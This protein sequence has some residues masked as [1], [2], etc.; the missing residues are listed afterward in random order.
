MGNPIYKNQDEPIESRIKD[1]LSRMTV[2]EKVGQMTQIERS[3]ATPSVIK[4]LCIGSILSCGGSGPFEKATSSDWAEMVDS[5]QKS[6]LDSRLGIPILYG[7]D[8]VHGN[9]NVYGA[10]VFPHNI[11]LGA[12]RKQATAADMGQLNSVLGLKLDPL[13]LEVSGLQG[14]PPEGYPKNYPF[15]AGRTNVV[16]CA[17]HFVGD[18]GTEQGV[19]EGN[20]KVSYEDLE[21]IHMA[22]YLDCLSQ[23]VCTVMAS[24]SSWNGTNLH[25][26]HFLLTEILK[27]KLGFKVMVPFRYK[28]YLEDLTHLVESGEIP[29]SRIDDA[30]ERI[31]RVKFVV[32]LFEYP[33]SDKS[34]L[35]SVGS[36]PRKESGNCFKGTVHSFLGRLFRRLKLHGK[37]PEFP[38]SANSIYDEI[39]CGFRS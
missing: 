21:R 34:L 23:G 15:V 6:A 14:Q 27:E 28:L 30:V 12:T 22:P 1:L 33:L 37:S 16:A 4:D 29:M 38:M 18:G 10:T 36:K 26:S 7:I 13:G 20:T 35:D 24:Y 39:S 32:G 8:A 25:E 17:K 3:V 19:N 11:G 2:K 31:L 9:N 5:F